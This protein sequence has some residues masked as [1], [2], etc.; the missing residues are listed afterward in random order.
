MIHCTIYAGSGMLHVTEQTEASCLGIVRI[1]ECC[2]ITMGDKSYIFYVLESLFF[3]N[4][5]HE[6][7]TSS[8]IVL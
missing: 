7:I 1:L 8:F 6:S 4:Q 5:S 2:M 3:S